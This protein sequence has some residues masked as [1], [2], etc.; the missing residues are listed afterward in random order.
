ML[1]FEWKLV[2]S[3]LFGKKFIIVINVFIVIYIL[4]ISVRIRLEIWNVK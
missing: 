3:K 1:N 4:L 2:K